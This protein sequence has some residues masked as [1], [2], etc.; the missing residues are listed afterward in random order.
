[1]KSISTYLLLVLVAVITLMIFL[2]LL[3]GYQSSIKKAELLF[4]S[5]LKNMAEIVANANQDLSPR[6]VSIFEQ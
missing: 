1:M 4:D 2:S 3:Q 6:D 5:R